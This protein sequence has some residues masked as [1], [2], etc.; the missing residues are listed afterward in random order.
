MAFPGNYGTGEIK[1]GSSN[2]MDHPIIDP[3]FLSN[4]FDKRTAIE[5]VRETLDFLNKPLMAKGLKR[6]AAAPTGDTDEEILV[7]KRHPTEE[8]LDWASRRIFNCL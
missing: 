2:P 5:S 1:L 4:P 8:N 6:F 7:G 3:K